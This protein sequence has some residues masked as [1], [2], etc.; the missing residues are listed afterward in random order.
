[1]TPKTPG[2][3]AWIYRRNVVGYVF[4]LPWLIGFFAF[5]VVPMLGSL[6]LSFT[7]Y[8]V[9]SA[10]VWIG[11]DNFTRMF[12]GD[13]RFW[14][15]VSVTLFF[16]VAAVP[17]RLAFALLVAILLDKDTKPAGLYRSLFYLPSLIG[18]S[19]VVAVL[20]K[21]LFGLNGAINSI[22]KALGLGSGISWISDPRSAIWVLITL[23][24]WQFGSS[25]LIF[26][27][28]LKQIPETYYEAAKIDGASGLRRFFSITLPLLTPIIFFNLIMMLI[29]SFM[30]F[31][32][33]YI[34][35]S[36]GPTATPGGPLDST[37]LYVL[38]MYLRAFQWFEMGYSSAMAWVL[39]I[40]VGAVTAL[41]FKSS[42]LWV[43]YEVKE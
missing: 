24:V 28:G 17:L 3:M 43:H 35:T 6:Y 23:N 20:W 21:E 41:I 4:I 13:E 33:A 2:K 11:F 15:S 37:L 22:I 31:T 42:S 8:K 25:M 14:K 16:V 19:V 40:V 29:S 38:Y 10:P 18:G 9:V 39:L 27:A 30:S 7:S 5:Q 32:S 34:I 26:V 12:G 1:M 36:A